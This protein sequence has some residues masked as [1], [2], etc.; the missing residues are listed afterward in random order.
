MPIMTLLH[1][2]CLDD[3]HEAMS[4]EQRPVDV[5]LDVLWLTWQVMK[6]QYDVSKPKHILGVSKLSLSSIVFCSTFQFNFMEL[7]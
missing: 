3:G 6:W 1:M 5:I 7:C 2:T 4:Q